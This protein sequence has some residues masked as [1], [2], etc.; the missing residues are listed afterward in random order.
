MGAICIILAV[1]FYSIGILFNKLLFDSQPD[2]GVFQF[3]ALR[4]LVHLFVVLLVV[5]RRIVYIAWT[6]V[7]PRSW[8]YLLIRASAI[9][10]SFTV[11]AFAVEAVPLVEIAL[12]INT[13]PLLLAVMGYFIFGDVLKPLN[14]VLLLLAFVGIMFLVLGASATD[15]VGSESQSLS[16][17]AFLVLAALLGAYGQIA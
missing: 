10:F 16:A 17:I 11:I 6:S 7:S 5:N 1:L 14:L 9:S 3:V 4:S 8:K 2:F 12:I 15:G 13:Q